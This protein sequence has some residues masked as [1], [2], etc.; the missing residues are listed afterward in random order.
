MVYRVVVVF[1]LGSI[2]GT[3]FYMAHQLSAIRWQLGKVLM[4][5]SSPLPSK[6]NGVFPSANEFYSVW[7]ARRDYSFVG[8]FNKWHFMFAEDYA[9]ELL[10]MQALGNR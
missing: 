3:L 7:R 2:L 4:M 9:S 1:A 5:L 6:K 8:E 10:K